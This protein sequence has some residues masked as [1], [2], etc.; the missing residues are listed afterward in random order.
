MTPA[1]MDV[2]NIGHMQWDTADIFPSSRVIVQ[3]REMG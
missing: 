1:E 2:C 3:V